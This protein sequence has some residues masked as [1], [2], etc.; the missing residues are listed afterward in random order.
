MLLSGVANICALRRCNEDNEE[1]GNQT[2]RQYG[3]ASELINLA[4]R[5]KS[6]STLQ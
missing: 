1:G 4:T 6:A 5:I 2:E 3:V